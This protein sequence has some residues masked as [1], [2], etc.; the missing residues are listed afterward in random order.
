MSKSCILRECF[1][2]AS[3]EW[4]RSTIDEKVEALQK[5]IKDDGE[6]TLKL[7]MGMLDYCNE[8]EGKKMP[9]STLVF[10]MSELLDHLLKRP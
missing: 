1:D 3:T 2:S 9:L 10:S 5:L 6:N 8:E 7:A 4:N